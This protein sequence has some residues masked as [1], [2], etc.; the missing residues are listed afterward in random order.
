MNSNAD[1]NV[2]FFRGGNNSEQGSSESGVTTTERKV[3][4][5][6]N[7]SL[8]KLLRVFRLS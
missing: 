2:V 7:T 6:W 3:Y 1:S 5:L 4:T 8:K